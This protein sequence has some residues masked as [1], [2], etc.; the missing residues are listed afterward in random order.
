MRLPGAA[1]KGGFV[2][3]ALLLV[4]ALA[5]T[6]LR[7]AFDPRVAPDSLGASLGASR[8]V[9]APD[10]ASAPDPVAAPDPAGAPDP[11]AAPDTVGAP[12]AVGAPDSLGAPQALDAPDSTGEQGARSVWDGVYTDEQANRGEAVYRA[13]C[14]LCHLRDLRGDGFASGLVDRAFT[15]RWNNRTLGDLYAITRS[16]MPQGAPASLSPQDY[17]DIAAF[18][19]KANGYPVGEE[20]LSP[21]RPALAQVII[22]EGR[23]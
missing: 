8:A 4:T 11:V 10:A 12:D 15:A 16:T 23:R 7:H 2:V 6:V 18:L 21:D 9:A 14:Q 17:V 20:E 5:V 1:T 3:L 19:L 22:A 13:Q